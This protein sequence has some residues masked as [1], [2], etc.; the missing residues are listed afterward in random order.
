MAEEYFKEEIEVLTRMK[1]NGFNPKVIYDVG[2]AV[3]FWSSTIHPIF[4]DS[5]YHIFEPLLGHNQE[6]TEKMK[7]FSSGKNVSTYDIALG[8]ENR[9]IDFFIKE[10]PYSSTAIIMTNENDYSEK[11]QVQSRRLDDLIT[12][13]Q[14][15]MPEF[16]KIDVQGYEMKILEGLGENIK[17]VELLLLETWLKRGY[18]RKTPLINEL[19]HFLTERGFFMYDLGGCYRDKENALISQDFF[20]INKESHHVRNHRL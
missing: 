2:G 10:S 13:S 17:N 7:N 12:N 3:G 18:G 16:I 11:I 20:F 9:E 1:S 15:P 8:D 4:P 5:S 19:Q 14:L 6:F